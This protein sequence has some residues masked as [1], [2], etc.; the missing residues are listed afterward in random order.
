MVDLLKL[1]ELTTK[2]MHILGMCICVRRSG[3]CVGH[4]H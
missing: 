1:F 3:K 4:K 2:S